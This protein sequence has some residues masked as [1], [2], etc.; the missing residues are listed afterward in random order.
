M[1]GIIKA[2]ET[3]LRERKAWLA[4]KRWLWKIEHKLEPERSHGDR[5]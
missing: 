3:V 4:L 5:A 1:L 2:H